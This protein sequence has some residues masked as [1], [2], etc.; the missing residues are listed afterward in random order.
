MG[1]LYKLVYKVDFN[2][3]VNIQDFIDELRCKNGNLEIAII[4]N[5]DSIEEL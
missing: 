2:H 4:D 1:S 5:S 3:G